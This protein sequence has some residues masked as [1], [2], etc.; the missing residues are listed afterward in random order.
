[1]DKASRSCAAIAKQVEDFYKEQ[2]ELQAAKK[3]DKGGKT[4]LDKEER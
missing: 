2:L 4:P 3:K 1:L